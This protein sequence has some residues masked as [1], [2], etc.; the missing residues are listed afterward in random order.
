MVYKAFI[1]HSWAQKDFVNK[2]A[3][4]I[5]RDK[6][7][8]DDHD[9]EKTRS[10]KDQILQN[11]DSCQL[12]VLVLSPEA[13][14]SDWIQFELDE[15]HRK[16][17]NRSVRDFCPIQLGDL[18]LDDPKLPDWLKQNLIYP[19]TEHLVIGKKIQQRLREIALKA[20]PILQQRENI[21]VTRSSLHDNFDKSL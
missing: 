17:E 6:C 2:I 3:D 13:L 4:Y 9:F 5:G 18:N 21:Y 19:I 12:Y 10:I 15:I 8:V 16:L 11:I 7:I 14:Q 1:S 20:D